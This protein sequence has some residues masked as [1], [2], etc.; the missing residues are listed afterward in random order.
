MDTKALP[1]P[2]FFLHDGE[3]GRLDFSITSLG[4]QDQLLR[5]ISQQVPTTIPNAFMLGES[6]CHIQVKGEYI[7]VWTELAK[8]DLATVYAP[9]STGE[10]YPVFKKAPT[11]D[12][13]E[14]TR[15]ETW[16]PGLVKLKV[17]FA[18]AFK[19]NKSD[20][21][22]YADDQTCFLI[23]RKEETN[24][25]IRP[26]LP[27]LYPDGRICMGGL[28]VVE[29]VVEIGFGKALTHLYNSR[30]NSDLSDGLDLD[31][32]KKIFTFKDGKNQPPPARFDIAKVAQCVAI[33]HQ[34]YSD[35]P[36]S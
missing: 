3:I 21:Q 18:V 6:I 26:P 14:V 22:F 13:A 36:V 10:F 30:W 28:K 35:L 7:V 5:D 15:T 2:L 24:K 33:N 4:Q 20:G 8:L 9:T 32:I 25:N 27:N 1:N 12:T 34:L 23:G 31:S 11:R 16:L 19:I 29:K 17:Y